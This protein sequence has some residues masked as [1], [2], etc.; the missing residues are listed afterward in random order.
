MNTKSNFWLKL[1]LAVSSMALMVDMAIYP[2]ADA[3]YTVFADQNIAL[4]NFV[5]TGPSLMIVIGSLLCGIA[6]QK[7]GKKKILSF[8]YL[9]FCISSIFAGAVDNIWYLIIMRTLMGLSA[10]FINISSAGLIAELFVDETVMSKMMGAYT[11]V[12]SILGAIL[13]MAAG[14]LALMDWHYVF[15]LYVIA[16]PILFLIVKNTPATPPEGAGSAQTQ[17]GDE[18]KTN[19]RRPLSLAVAAFTLNSGY[20]VVLTMMAVFLAEQQI[21]NSATAG[22]VGMIATLGSMAASFLFSRTYMIFKR[23][24]PIVFAIIMGLGF[25]MLAYSKALF[26]VCAASFLMGAMYG[27]SYSYYLMYA[28]MVV[29]A[30]KSSLSISIANAAVYLGLFCGPYV[31]PF[32]EG[33]FRVDTMAA[34][35]PYIAVTCF[36]Y[37]VISV[38]LNVRSGRQSV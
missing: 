32:Y 22:T 4:V 2:A 30:S 8:A 20:A 17:D 37:A 25:L 35:M 31:C 5:I 13:S 27:T 1:T 9:V 14:Y 21:G 38:I 10:G 24:T 6:T 11:G 16:V 36:L 18:G 3:I 34:S 15:Y 33:I 29:P 23:K 7:I 19:W 26:I 12:M 28:A